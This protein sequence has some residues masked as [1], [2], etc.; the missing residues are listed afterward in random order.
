MVAG[1]TPIYVITPNLGG[2]GTTLQSAANT[3]F[4]GTGSV[5]TAFTAGANGSYLQNITFCPQGGATNNVASVARVFVNNGLQTAS[6]TN[7]IFIGEVSLP[8][9][10][11]SAV[12]GLPPIVLPL[13]FPVQANYRVTW[14]LGTAVA[15][16][17][18]AHVI[19]GDY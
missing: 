16:G 19:G 9:T 11:G 10:T 7:N 6:A 1:T 2:I 12:A 4:D 13:N 18:W 17:Y 3:A 5:V 15:T 14:A 8:A